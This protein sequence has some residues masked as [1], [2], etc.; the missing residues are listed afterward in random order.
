[1]LKRL[2]DALA[3]L[4]GR[5]EPVI[6]PPRYILRVFSD[7]RSATELARSQYAAAVIR[8]DGIDKWCLFACPCGCGQ[9]IALN[10]MKS[11]FPRWRVDTKRDG[12]FSL[13]P[14]VDSTTCGA[15]FLIRNS[16]VVWCEGPS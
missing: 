3:R 11:H 4:V 12:T 10:L 16:L 6:I 8:S 13:Y 2:F 15:H 14:S 5:A 7:R 1:M 9:Q